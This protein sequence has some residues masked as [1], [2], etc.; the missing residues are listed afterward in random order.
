MSNLSIIGPE[1]RAFLDRIG[2]C[3]ID[4]YPLRRQGQPNR[5]QRGTDAFA[6]FIDHLIGKTHNHHRRQTARHMD[7]NL[8]GN[9]FDAAK[10]DGSDARMHAVMTRS[11]GSS[12]MVGRQQNLILLYFFEFHAGRLQLTREPPWAPPARRREHAYE[13]AAPP[14]DRP[15]QHSRQHGTRFRQCRSAR[16]HAQSCA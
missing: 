12:I 14:D 5:G 4:R 2:R 13:G 15:G 8:D 9:G 1:M 7:L 10:D 6:R 3:Q 11:L 16:Q